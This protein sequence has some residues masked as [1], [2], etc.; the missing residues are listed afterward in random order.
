MV[1][2]LIHLRDVGVLAAGTLRTEQMPMIIAKAKQLHPNAGT[3]HA[4]VG[5]LLNTAVGQ[6]KNPTYQE[7]A[8]WEF[9]LG[10]EGWKKSSSRREH[11]YQNI[12]HVSER[13][14]RRLDKY[15][16][17]ILELTASEIQAVQSST[18][19]SSLDT[20]ATPYVLRTELADAIE[21]LLATADQDWRWRRR[22]TIYL[23][24]EP[25]TGKSRLAREHFADRDSVV[26]Q[27]DSADALLL[28]ITK[29]LD[30]RGGLDST[31]TS[32][33][34]LRRGFAALLCDASA[35]EIVILDGYA[36]V[37]AVDDLL[38][39]VTRSWIIVTG[40]A[41]P[42]EDHAPVVS[43]EE[44][45]N[46][47]SEQLISEQCPELDERAR[48]I[49]TIT[50][51]GRVRAL[52][53]ACA[54]LNQFGDIDVY[55][56]CRSVRRDVTSV[57]DASAP[58]GEQTLSSIYR[59]MLSNL[60]HEKR[61][62]ELLDFLAFAGHS[63]L[64]ERCAMAYL[65]VNPG[66]YMTNETTARLRYVSAMRPLLELGIVH[67]NGSRV[68]LDTLTAQIIRRL[69]HENRRHTAACIYGY[70]T[71]SKIDQGAWEACDLI[72]AG[73]EPE[74]VASYFASHATAMVRLDAYLLISD[75]PSEDELEEIG[76]ADEFLIDPLWE[77][78]FIT[79]RQGQLTYGK[80]YAEVLASTVKRRSS[81]D[82]LYTWMQI[83]KGRKAASGS[84]STPPPQFLLDLLETGPPTPDDM[85]DWRET[86]GMPRL[87]SP[88]AI[89]RWVQ[90][91]SLVLILEGFRDF[92]DG[93]DLT[94][95][96]SGKE[97]A[98]GCL[99]MVRTVGSFQSVIDDYRQQKMGS[100]HKS[101]RRRKPR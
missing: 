58:R 80:A 69:R 45:T 53:Q 3:V 13:H 10:E 29:V 68:Y 88:K 73:W 97:L 101:M 23:I 7:A 62:L 100:A 72:D 14:F 57:L 24:G 33:Y 78:I 20:R 17:R 8:R 5:R 26:L 31:T 12:L 59:R 49:I 6:I 67:V 82:F 15:E 16:R 93:P 27:A 43:V 76:T 52:N 36:D 81:G 74:D 32:A 86:L 39:D 84:V 60:Q 18:Q 95:M 42:P 35:P 48:S 11:I 71:S 96:P 46:E 28:S 87:K 30:A 21:R 64:T 99:E 65:V 38:P 19:S 66:F 54:L 51:G 63:N 94:D 85:N 70:A 55:D 37:G 56:F 61:A 75:T 9:G 40:S 41:A 50:M 79:A 92:A 98:L 4:A 1:R 83:S 77:L 91:Y 89:E 90:T 34:A 22:N 2:E 47:E 44:L 25:G